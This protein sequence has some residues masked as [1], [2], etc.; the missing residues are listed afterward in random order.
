MSGIVRRPG[1]IWLPSVEPELPS[2][3]RPPAPTKIASGA[4]PGWGHAS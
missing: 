3:Q 1:L 4:V 2:K